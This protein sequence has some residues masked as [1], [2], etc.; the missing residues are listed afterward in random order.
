MNNDYIKS[1]NASWELPHAIKLSTKELAIRQNQQTRDSYNQTK[2]IFYH[3]LLIPLCIPNISTNFT[4]DHL[5]TEI[6]DQQRL[7]RVT[8]CEDQ[9]VLF[10][11]SKG[12]ILAQQVL[13]ERF[14]IQVKGGPLV[15]V[16]WV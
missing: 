5:K 11:V 4:N 16:L 10:V 9:I 3:N 15:D 7:T 12:E 13:P 2:S 1:N 8:C 14:K 6:D